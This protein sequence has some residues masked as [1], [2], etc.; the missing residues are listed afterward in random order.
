MQYHEIKFTT[1]KKAEFH[2]RF[3]SPFY[4]ENKGNDAFHL[5]LHGK[6]EREKIW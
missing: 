2:D 5:T 1:G 6:Q 3:K 4:K